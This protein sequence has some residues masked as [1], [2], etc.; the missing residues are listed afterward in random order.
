[1]SK[2]KKKG[3]ISFVPNSN[4]TIWLIEPRDPLIFRNGK[5]FTPTPG[6][7]AQSLPFPFPSTTTGGLRSKIGIDKGIF[8]QEG[9]PNN[10]EFKNLKKL[11]VCGP[12]LAQLDEHQ[13]VATWLLPAPADALLL[14]PEEEQPE[15]AD[16]TSAPQ[17]DDRVQL[18]QL[19]PL[20]QNMIEYDLK[21]PE[22]KE[23]LLLVGL[24]QHHEGKPPKSPRYW[25]WE[26]YLTWL[27]NP[28]KVCRKIRYTSELGLNGPQ[29][30]HRTHVAMDHETHS[31]KDGALFSTSGLEFMQYDSANHETQD[32]NQ[33]MPDVS[34][35]HQLAL[36]MILEKETAFSPEETYG[37]LGGERRIVNWHKV[38]QDK[39]AK[40][41][42]IPT[43]ILEGIKKSQRCR[44]ILLTPA[45][46]RNG[47]Y[48]EWILQKKAGVQ[49]KLV[50]LLNQ[51]PQV[52]SGWSMEGDG[53]RKQTRRLTPAGSVLYLTLETPKGNE[54]AI[55]DWVQ[56]IWLSNISDYTSEETKSEPDSQYSLD[57]FGLAILGLWNKQDKTGTPQQDDEKEA[58]A[59]ESR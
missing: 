41:L 19:I 56:Q 26:Q 20:E 31:G 23:K 40:E 4:R 24:P 33:D 53:G 45:Y 49:P 59:C 21:P 44:L 50:A 32:I 5:P 29:Y 28:E 1:M 30:E 54:A 36:A 34:K 58:K 27:K 2:H 47:Y 52:V 46:F 25:R 37:T 9:Y 6:A 17:P 15:S 11:Y 35:I 12:L 42:D 7:H 8:Q 14:K 57:G 16:T 13:N 43:E 48:P 51:P 22:D 38:K 39:T 18:H 10:A 3:K 55:G